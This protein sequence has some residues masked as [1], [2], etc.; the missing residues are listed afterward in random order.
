MIV[1]KLFSR[2]FDY[3]DKKRKL[4]REFPLLGQAP[5]GN[6]EVF[7]LNDSPLANY[8][9]VKIVYSIAAATG[10]NKESHPES[11]LRVPAI[12]N[13]L[14]DMELTPKFLGSNI[15]QLENYKPASVDDIVSVHSKSYVA[16]LEKAMDRASRDGLILIEGSGPT[17]ATATVSLS[18]DSF[19]FFVYIS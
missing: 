2:L 4:N 18:A 9:N 15:I 14:E 8:D 7:C 1:L 13:A 6:S 3:L 16:G 19:C 17:Y 5:V 12:A 10:H 11:H